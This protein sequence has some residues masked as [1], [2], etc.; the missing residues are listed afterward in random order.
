MVDSKPEALTELLPAGAC[1]TGHVLVVDDDPATRDLLR[2]VL[3]RDGHAVSVARHGLEAVAALQAVQFDVLILD[4]RMPGLGGIEVLSLLPAPRPLT[5]VMSG[6][7]DSVVEA[8][9]QHLGADAV[10]AKPFELGE[11][12][13]LV[14]TLL[15]RRALHA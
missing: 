6:F 12:R 14:A 4:V 7:P 1:H 2:D 5:V 3:R 9:A 10:L 13:V 8:A 11:L 15:G